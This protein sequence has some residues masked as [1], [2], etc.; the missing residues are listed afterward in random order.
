VKFD[1]LETAAAAPARFRISV[2]VLGVCLLLLA[3]GGGAILYFQFGTP[4][5]A[6]ATTPAATAQGTAHIA[7][8]PAG[9]RVTIDGTPRGVTPL[10]LSLAPGDH[11]LLVAHGATTRTLPLTIEAGTVVKQYV[12]LGPA[13]AVA[14]GRIEIVSEPANASVTI[15]G[16]A[17]G[18]TPLVVNDVAPGAH[19]V[20]IGTGDAAVTRSVDVTA[21]ATASVMVSMTPTTGTAGWVAVKSPLPLELYE[22]GKLLAAA[23]VERLMLPTGRHELEVAAPEFGFRAT[24]TVNVQ[25]G[26]TVN[27]AIA[28]PNGLLSINAVPW[29]E[30]L[31]D[32]K[33]L[34]TTPLAN[35]SV[36]IGTH[37]IVFKHPQFGE[38]RQIVKVNAQTPVRAGMDF[39]K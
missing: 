35:L 3:A 19:T 34:G 30:V 10:Q 18:I 26:R 29:A 32:G 24:V 4:P 13:A 15:D 23:G 8:V 39:G 21:G 7:S 17:A 9:A 33:P 31:L 14:G 36:P 2:P 22:G 27:A 5:L 28:V 16:V 37:E 6:A 12:D 25:P 38:R 20:T 1:G 11:T